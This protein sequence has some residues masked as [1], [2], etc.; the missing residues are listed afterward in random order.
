MKRDCEMP[1]KESVA[2]YVHNLSENMWNDQFLISY[3]Y[4]YRNVCYKED[5]KIKI[6]VRISFRLFSF[7]I[8]I[9]I[10]IKYE[11]ICRPRKLETYN[12]C[13]FNIAPRL[14]CDFQL[15][16]F[17]NLIF[18]ITTLKFCIYMY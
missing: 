17:T 3:E 12:I 8:N 7:T 11:N 16:F 5:R 18:F 15:D 9:L 4:I 2:K 10:F 6:T 13:V 14:L 1:G